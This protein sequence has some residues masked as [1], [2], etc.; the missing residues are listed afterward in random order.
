MGRLNIRDVCL[1]HEHASVEVARS[2]V[3]PTC[4]VRVEPSAEA[5]D[6]QLW[7]M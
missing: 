2:Y 5:V 4:A 6:S 3:F 7:S 1:T